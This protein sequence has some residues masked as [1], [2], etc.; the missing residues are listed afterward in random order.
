MENDEV[1]TYSTEDCV[2]YPADILSTMEENLKN[3]FMCI[4]ESLCHPTEIS[5]VNLYFN[6]NTLKIGKEKTYVLIIEHSIVHFKWV[7]CLVCELHISIKILRENILHRK[8]LV[9]VF[10]GGRKTQFL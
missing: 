9:H 7:N 6:K 3:N 2:Q 8:R 1:L 10:M 5:I 4:I